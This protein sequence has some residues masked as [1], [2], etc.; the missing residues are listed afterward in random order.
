MLT[1]KQK[2]FYDGLRQ[3]VRERE[4][5]PSVREIGSELG[6][7]SPA[8]VHAYL[9]KLSAEGKIIK[10]QSGWA[11]KTESD[12]IPLMGYVP[13]GSSF[14][15]FEDLGEEVRVPQWMMGSGELRALRVVGDSM[16]DAYIQEGDIVIIKKC[17]Q[18]ESNEMVIAIME[19]NSITLKRLKKD[20]QKAWL[21]PEN[22]DY[23]P[24]FDPFRIAGKV[25]SVLRKYI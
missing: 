7:S 2:K 24:I 12:S 18:A 3:M 20:G 16:K 22:P 15:V 11:I 17:L 21:V 25:I 4:Y 10:D 19:D 23:S 14:E 9:S 13:A 6:F 1:R 5:F 8:T